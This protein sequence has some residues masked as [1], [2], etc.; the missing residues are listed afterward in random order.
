[1]KILFRVDAGPQIGLG[2]LQRCL[3]LATAIRHFGGDCSFLTNEETVGMDRIRRSGFDGVAL[4]PLE[5]WGREDLQRTA[6]MASRKRCGAIVVDS[7]YEGEAYLRGLRDKR[8]FVCALEDMDPHPFPCQMV[9]N[10]DAHAPEL[11]RMPFSREPLFLLGPEYAILRHE[12]WK[13][14]LRVTRREVQNVLVTLGGADPLDLMPRILGLLKDLPGT[15]AV[16]AIVGPFF[17][18]R[19]WIGRLTDGSNRTVKVEE[20]PDWVRDLM[21]EADV[22]VSAAG[23]TLY[24]LACVG[25][26]TIAVQVAEN[27]AGQLHAL[28]KAG[29]IRSAGEAAGA[30]L[31][32]RIRDAFIPLL[33]EPAVR[34]SMAQVGQGL[35]DGRGALRVAH[36]IL[37]HGPFSGKRD[38]RVDLEGEVSIR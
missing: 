25:C 21:W 3:S 29:S 34:A 13:V 4:G 26:P 5:S 16:T 23:Q 24:E 11:Y 32:K 7:D 37:T 15:F 9:V 27:Q 19:A 22:A 36:A 6:A 20:S 12:F 14:P 1:M 8:F 30:H 10:G 18:N 35:V 2:H 33:N 38:Y 31:L 28:E 17:K